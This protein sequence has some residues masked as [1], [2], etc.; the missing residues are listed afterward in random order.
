MRT[1]IG[2]HGLT[3]SEQWSEAGHF[4]EG[5]DLELTEIHEEDGDGGYGE[6]CGYDPKGSAEYAQNKIG[7]Y[8]YAFSTLRG[9][10]NIALLMGDQMWFFRAVPGRD[11]WIDNRISI[12]VNPRPVNSTMQ[13]TELSFGGCI[14]GWEMVQIDVKSL[15]IT[16]GQLRYTPIKGTYKSFGFSLDAI[17]V[18]DTGDKT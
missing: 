14:D 7:D 4:I 2:T 6:F 15:K 3:K 16:S 9:K 10:R 8:D 1:F 17:P 5:V 12:F 18:V 11:G 13:R